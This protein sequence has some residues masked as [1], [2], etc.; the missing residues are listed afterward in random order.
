MNIQQHTHAYRLCLCL[1]AAGL[2][3]HAMAEELL[4]SLAASAD[5]FELGSGFATAGDLNGDGVVDVAVA[6]RSARVNTLYASGIVHLVSGTDGSLIRNYTGV[7]AASQSFGTSLASLNA[8][9]D[10]VPD[11][12]IGAPG[13]SDASGY[14]AGAVRIY[15]GATGSMLAT[16]VGASGSQLGASLANAGDQNGDGLDDLYVGAPYAN[17]SRGAVFVISGA[18]A[19]TLRT[20]STAAPVGAFGAT[21]ARLGDVDGDGLADVAVAAPGFRVST[22][23]AGQVVLVRSS[24]GSNA[25][26]ITGSGLYNRLGE[27]LAPA[28][29]ANGDGLP[30]L[31]VGSYSGGTARLVSGAD[32]S[33]LSDLSV[34][35]PSFRRLMVGG[36]LDFNRDGT[37]DWLIG[38]T[39][40]QVVA[41]KVVGGI[42]VVSGTDHA[43]LFELTATAPNTDLG[44]SVRV[45]PGLGM[46]AGE[47][48][49][50]DPISQGY[51]LARVWKVVEILD[52][53]GDGI[54]DDVDMV[55]NSIMD[56]TILILGV[57]SGVTNTLDAQGMTLADRFAELGPQ[58]DYRNPA[59]YFVEVNQFCQQLVDE[60]L[61]DP[62]ASRQI[63]VA[64]LQNVKNSNANH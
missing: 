37:A 1:L 62:K 53:D 7:P 36:S 33:T 15:S 26:A 9:G 45:L 50:R 59:Q 6:D 51:G 16:I 18:S 5:N 34:T 17:S 24:D 8:D 11:L 28:A 25:A 27:S 54:S 35:L 42:R 60:G 64:A 58:S 41:G 39:G 30:D 44:L 10:G 21:L 47:T 48:S 2:C 55:T 29:D 12:A 46:A 63:F 57:D 4:F 13:Q 38:S 40:L 14:G 43:T 31:L 20:I 32:L 61:I 22:N 49:L 19:T 3:T 56:A 52:T 23:Q